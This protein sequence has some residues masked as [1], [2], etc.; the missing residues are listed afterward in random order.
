[1]ARLYSQWIEDEAKDNATFVENLCYSLNE[2]R[3]QFPH[4]LALTFE[5]IPE[6]S[7]ILTEYANDSV[8]MEKVVAYGEVNAVNPKL[9]FLFGGQGSQWYA[10]GRQLIEMEPVFKDAFLTVHN[11]IKDLWKS[12]SLLDELMASEEKSRIAE[13]SIAQPATFAIQYATAKLLMSWRIYP[14]AVLVHSLGEIAAACIAGIITLKEAVHLVL[15]RSS[16]Q[17]QCPSNGSMAALGMSEERARALLDELKLTPTLCIAAINDA[18]SVTVS[19]DVESVEA[20][21]QHIAIHEKDTFWR[22]LGTKRAFHSSHME[23]I[24]RP[25]QAAMKRIS[26]HPKLSKIPMYST[27]EGG[28]LCGQEFNNEYWWRNIRCPVQFY[29]AMKHLLRDGYKQVIEISTQP[30]LAQYVKKIAMQENFQDQA[31]PIVLETLPRKRVPV[32]KQ[33]KSFLINTVCKL[34]T[35][36]FPI[37]WTC[38][39]TI[40][41]AKF[42]RSL[43]Y[44]WIKNTFWYRERPPQ[45]IIQPVDAKSWDEK[46]SHPFLEKVKQTSLYSGLHCWETE[47]DLHRFP[48][49]KDHALIQGTTVMPGATYLEMAFAMAMDQFVHVAGLE[50]SEVKLSSLLTLPETQVRSLRLRLQKTERINEAEY[51]ITSVQDDHSEI[52]LSSGKICLDLLQTQKKGNHKAST[53]AGPA[54]SELLKNMERM[55]NEQ[56]RGVTEKFGFNYG[57]TFS[58]IKE[59]WKGDN[60]GL[61][62][63]D[64][65]E[66]H[67]IQEE[68][69]R[70]VVYPSIL[71]ACLQ[72]CFVPLGNSSIDDKSIVPVGFKRVAL[73]DLLLT[74]Q[75][76]CHV[77]ANVS[78]FGRFDVTLMNPSGYVL[79]TMTDFRVAELTSSPRQLPLAD[80]AYD[81]QWREAELTRQGERTPPLT[82]IVLKDSSDL[83]NYLISS[84]QA[85]EVKVIAVNP[86]DGH[87]FDSEVQDTIKIAFA[88]FSAIN[89]SSL[90]V[91]NLWPVDTSLLPEHFDVIEQSQQLAFSSSVFLLELLIE[92][93]LMDSRLFL[94][95]ELTQLLDV[96]DHSGKGK[97]IPW[98]STVWGL[99]RTA[100]LEEFNLRVTTVDLS[101]KEDKREINSLVDE[102]LGDSVEDEVAFRD[103]KRFINRLVRSELQLHTSKRVKRKERKKDGLLYLSTVPPSKSHCLR[104]KCFPKATQSEVI[105]EVC[106]CWTPSESLFDVSKPN[107]C[108]FVSGKVSDLPIS[109][110]ST[111]QIGDNVCGVIPSGRVARFM[112]IHVSSVFLKPPNLTMEQATY[113]PACLALAFHA[114]QKAAAG[115]EKQKLL[116]N[117]A[118]RGPGP[119]AVFLGKHWVTE[120]T[121]QSQT[122]EVH[123]RK[124]FLLIWVQRV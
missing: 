54:I 82:F 25:F 44:P 70:Y 3:S 24:K 111:L 16:L 91:I 49:L 23:F 90:R 108:V 60:E 11:L 34:Y 69:G 96:C 124:G 9:V 95:T 62:L 66:A 63:I 43:T 47:I 112:P 113:L 116:I 4:R 79:L 65:A 105:V 52:I 122:L 15:A 64:I 27:V 20:L 98:G 85:R 22:V 36:G 84:L 37:D 104:E 101:N 51:H 103:S 106:Y 56:F 114:L 46:K 94:V 59:I 55:P 40:P 73:N 48:D 41:S 28:V 33:C 100:N 78:E 32:N 58:I 18:E 67:T 14:S 61:C 119:A 38:V 68:T 35:L 42:V 80:L 107:G 93:E 77:T 29:S 17:D 86:P 1:M 87:C 89:S 26:L 110:E 50:L 75:L 71:D 88:D 12:M 81:I 39:Q 115:A 92:K 99:R 120:C 53:A 57:P 10:M 97:F 30:I 6:A 102:V 7:K 76:F 31:K 2:R 13:N 21:G 45:N 123:A 109:G 83:S 121:A 118:N 117:E 5:A 8:G 74:S 72:S 19:G